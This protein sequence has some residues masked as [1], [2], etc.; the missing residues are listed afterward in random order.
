MSVSSPSMH[1]IVRQKRRASIPYFR[2]NYDQRASLGHH[3][4]LR[5]LYIDFPVT[6]DNYNPFLEEDIGI[7]FSVGSSKLK[8]KL[9][10]IPQE[11]FVCS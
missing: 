9:Q 3:Q 6:T 5:Y 4:A 8:F 11:W 2:W 1:R 10:F 7:F